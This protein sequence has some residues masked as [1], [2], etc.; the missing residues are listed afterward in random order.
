MYF[1]IYDSFLIDKKYT[2]SLNQL[3]TRVSDLG[4]S[5]KISR[6]T[7]LKNATELIQDFLKNPSPTIVVV[8]SDKLFYEAAIA[9]AGS[10]GVLGF[11]PLEPSSCL[12]PLL[13]LPAN[14]FGADVISARLIERIRFGKI[15]E[16]LFCSSIYFPASKTII[17]CEGAYQIRPRRIKSIKIVNLDLLKF[18]KPE[19][20]PDI[21]RIASNPKDDFLE[22]LMGAPA[23]SWWP[24]KKK[25]VRDSLFFAK[26]IKIESKK[27]G[28]EIPM[29]IDKERVQLIK[30]PAA[31]RVA[32][33]S[34][35]IIVGKGRLI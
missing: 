24:F 17:T 27:P 23:R 32:E 12:A 4:I 5:G 26:R 18:D 13:G 8:G 2:K 11:I 16:K 29:T 30:V 9:M 10:E 34:L 15:N 19:E 31:L 7:I 14:E 3:E 22:V 25:E 21:K 20:S 6:L 33:E 35:K 1:Y 28:L